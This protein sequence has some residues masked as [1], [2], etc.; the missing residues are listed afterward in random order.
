MTFMKIIDL[1]SSEYI[2][3]LCIPHA[4]SAPDIQFPKLCDPACREVVIS[5]KSRPPVPDQF[6]T[7][8]DA[9]HVCTPITPGSNYCET[10]TTTSR[11]RTI[12]LSLVLNSDNSLSTNQVENASSSPPS[13]TLDDNAYVDNYIYTPIC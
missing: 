1:F 13:S 12:R 2:S 8:S 7:F 9:R 4:I 6:L 11:F 3:F 5:D 10:V